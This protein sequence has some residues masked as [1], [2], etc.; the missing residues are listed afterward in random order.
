MQKSPIGKLFKIEKPIVRQR[1]IKPRRRGL[2]RA[3]I[4]PKEKLITYREQ[5][6]WPDVQL[7]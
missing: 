5:L 6:T 3:L 1:Q 2:V 7:H 4:Q